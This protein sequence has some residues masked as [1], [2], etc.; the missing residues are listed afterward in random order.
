MLT[1][2]NCEGG[3]E[4]FTVSTKENVLPQ[5]INNPNQSIDKQESSSSEKSAK[6]EYFD[7]PVFLTVSGQLHLEA[8]CNG[9]SKVIQINLKAL[10]YVQ[11]GKTLT[12]CKASYLYHYIRQQAFWFANNCLE[13]L[14][15]RS[16]ASF[17]A[18]EKISYTNLKLL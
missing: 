14:A 17:Y 9:I 11:R 3:G 2:N 5:S 4:V 10:T 8:M 1:S 13:A 18:K 6:I 7:K 16:S 12:L 15:I